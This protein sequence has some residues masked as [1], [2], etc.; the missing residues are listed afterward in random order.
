MGEIARVTKAEEAK[1]AGAAVPR[2]SRRTLRDS[3]VRGLALR[4]TANGTATWSLQYRP[5]GSPVPH[6]FMNAPSVM[7]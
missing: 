6:R 3:K 2:G 7:E 5:K 1:K 4:I